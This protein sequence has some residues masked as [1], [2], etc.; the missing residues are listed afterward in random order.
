[1]E[2]PQ[3]DTAARL[4]EIEYSRQMHNTGDPDA[5]VPCYLKVKFALPEPPAATVTF[6]VCVPYF[7]CHAVTV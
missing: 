5:H 2:S 3:F 7:S 4:L 6:A 1:V